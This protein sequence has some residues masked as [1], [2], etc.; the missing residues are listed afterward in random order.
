MCAFIVLSRGRINAAEHIINNEQH[1]VI[2]ESFKDI[3][4]E[5]KGGR[6]RYS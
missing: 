3:I 5:N 4:Y 6:G 1:N 2:V